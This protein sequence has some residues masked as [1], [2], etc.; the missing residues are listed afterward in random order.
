MRSIAGQLRAMGEPVLSTAALVVK[1]QV[2]RLRAR[3][4]RTCF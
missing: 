1:I 2:A 4:I 3:L